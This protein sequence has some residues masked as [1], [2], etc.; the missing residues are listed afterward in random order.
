MVMTELKFSKI[1]WIDY[2]A[3]TKEKLVELAP[4]IGVPRGMLMSCLDPDYLPYLDT[5]DDVR[6][7][8]LRI[9]EK[10]A[11]NRADTIQELTTKIAV[12]IK[13]DIIYSFHRLSLEELKRIAERIS[14]KKLALPPAEIHVQYFLNLLF[15]EVIM[16]YEKPL[17]SLEAQNSVF[18]EKILSPRQSKYFLR[19]GFAIKRKASAY[20]KIVKFTTDILNKSVILLH[21]DSNQYGYL[22]E[23]LDRFQFFAEDV[24]E[25]IQG[26][27]NLHLAIQSQKTN[28]ASFR[29]NEI[30]RVLTVL[31]IFFLPLNF[32]AGVFGMNFDI[33]PLVK[34]SEGFW[35][36]IVLMAMICIGLLLYTVKKGWLASPR[37][38]D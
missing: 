7:L 13:G 30:V 22:K 17:L 12:F 19:D 11:P 32:I 10:S 6:F 37:S 24:F 5:Y 29:T 2:Q 35:V 8:M 25:D 14:E 21:F 20:K 36:S 1:T 27:L 23:K 16:S 34:S 9:C 3:P 28:E 31:T 15:E 18:E 4:V 38:K 33:M 26:L